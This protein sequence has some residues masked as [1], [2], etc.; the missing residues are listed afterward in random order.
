MLLLVPLLAT[1]WI[2]IVDIHG[3]G[4]WLVVTAGLLATGDALS[5]IE[6]DSLPAMKR[7]DA[8]L[9]RNSAECIEMIRCISCRSKAYF[10]PALIL[11]ERTK[12]RTS[13][14]WS[15]RPR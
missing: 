9:E 10:R 3:I 6:V 5:V 1:R 14:I 12:R 11:L 2:P 15:M 8:S 13:A 7:V 4:T